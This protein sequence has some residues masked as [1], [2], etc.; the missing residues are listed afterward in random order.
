MILFAYYIYYIYLCS[1]VAE[2]T[3]NGVNDLLRLSPRKTKIIDLANITKIIE[4][5]VTK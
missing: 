3:K 1:A 2:A 5:Y 4:S